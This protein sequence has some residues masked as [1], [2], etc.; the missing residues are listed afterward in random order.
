MKLTQLLL[1]TL[2][3]LLPA[4]NGWAQT[5]TDE[6]AAWAS[7]QRQPLT[8]AT[9]RQRCDL[10]QDLGQTNLNLAY[11]RLA[12]LVAL[13]R[14]TGNQRW[15]HI[16]LINWGKANE[17]LN[18]Y[19]EADSLFR[20]ARQNA[21]TNPRFYADALTY[22]IQLYFDWD[23]P[24]SLAHYLALGEAVAKQAN[25]REN[26][27]LQRSIRAASKSRT[28]DRQA[29]LADFDEAIRLAT[30]LP[31]KNALFIAKYGRASGYLTTPQQQVMAFDS[32]LALARD[33]T[34]A[35][36]PRF[37]E[38][39]TI[40]YRRAEPTLLFKLAQLNLLLADYDNA[41]KFADLF[42]DKLIRPNPQAPNVPFINAEMAIIRVY[43][44][45]IP[46]A[47]A[48]LDSSRRQFGVAETQIPYSG[49]FIA[50][51]L[52]AEH[53]G[54][55]AKAV[56]YYRQALT[57]GV[58]SASFSPIPPELFYVRAL[59]RTNQY[60]KA[61]QMLA[62]LTASVT[63]N[64][65]SAIGLY[66][67]QAVAEL[68][69]AQGNYPRYGQHLGMYYAIRDSLTSLNQYRA[70]QQILAGVRIRDKEQQI[71]RLNAESAARLVQIRRERWFY[72]VIIA[73]A[74]LTIG[75]LVLSVRNRQIRARQREALQQSQMEQLEQQQQIDLMVRVMEAEASER[76]TM[77]DELH[78]E[79]NPLLTVVALNISSALEHTMPESPTDARLHKAQEVLTTVTSTVRGI[80]HR[81]T[82]RLIEA[83]GFKR[84]VEE[85]AE[86]VSLSGKIRIQTIVVGFDETLPVLFLSDLYRIAQELVHNVI[87]HAEA[88]EA[89]LEII[90]HDRHVTI[91]IDDNGIGIP[92]DYEG[93]G[94]G[95]ATIR[96]KV[97]LRHGQM[98]VQRKPN[99]GTLVVIDNL[100]VPESKIATR[101]TVK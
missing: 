51:G 72:G 4:T 23:K 70:V 2:L 6:P 62:P 30:G 63:T 8:E 21:K 101:P 66:Y 69:K 47:R 22:T 80:S 44:G 94:Q 16:L 24:D 43:Q 34:L 81:L 13:V 28:G 78:N 33:S 48:F 77:A 42:Y 31:N 18:H 56:D 86:S 64:P 96:A 49:Y 50:A 52:L 40:Y 17:S 90:E 99:G 53:D 95:L 1:W 97:A 65:Y 93:D 61:G 46:Q 7:L 5:N 76:H 89:I 91:M 54:R 84:A 67:Y 20:V 32:L 68:D 27:S 79:V 88:T 98:E 73:L 60:D 9:F 10:I 75:L 3:L 85:L 57:K 82:P 45:Q 19:P 92:T 71:D 100:E 29:M 39:T 87:R 58:T 26:L 35:N 55:L 14:K 38:R 25:D 11:K 37:Y 41:G 15:L 12:D 74:L 83:Y 59:I 36:N